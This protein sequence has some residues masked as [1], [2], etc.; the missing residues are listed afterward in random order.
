MKKRSRLIFIIAGMLLSSC[1]SSRPLSPV[2]LPKPTQPT[3]TT[4]LD[5]N[6]KD[7]EK[8]LKKVSSDVEK[9]QKLFED[10]QGVPR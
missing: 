2:V 8:S 9:L 10:L 3:G 6:I 1:A 5:N 7:I 4:E